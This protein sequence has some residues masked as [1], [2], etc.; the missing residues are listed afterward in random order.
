MVAVSAILYAPFTAPAEMVE[1]AS[2]QQL[3]AV[4]DAG[5]SG[6]TLI[7][8]G[9]NTDPCNKPFESCNDTCKSVDKLKS[10]PCESRGLMNYTEA[11]VPKL[12]E[13][14]AQCLQEGAKGYPGLLP[15]SYIV[16]AG[17]I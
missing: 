12:R 10:V 5:D 6:T 13:L 2:T 17:K 3:G 16:P 11:E 4:V 1:V 7:V 8:Y 15:V 14:I 9:C